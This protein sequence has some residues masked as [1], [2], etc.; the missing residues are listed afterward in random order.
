MSSFKNNTDNLR[1]FVKSEP[2]KTL[3]IMSAILVSESAE[4]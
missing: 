2:D 3:A 1:Q 4:S